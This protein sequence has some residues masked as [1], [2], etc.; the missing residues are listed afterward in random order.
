MKDSSSGAGGLLLSVVLLTAV[1]SAARADA[2]QLTSTELLSGPGITTARYTSTQD[3]VPS[4][5]VLTF[6]DNTVTFTLAKG[7][8]RRA[9]QYVN[10]FGDFNPGTK[11]LYTNNNNFK[12]FDLVTTVGGGGSGPVEIDFATGVQLVG[13]RA[14]TGWTGLE[15]FTF[16][17]YNDAALLGT[18]NT[19]G[20][21]DKRANDEFTALLAAEAT[22]G[23]VITRLVVSS[24][25]VQGGFELPNDFFIGPLSFGTPEPATA[26]PEPSTITMTVLGLGM[27]GSCRRQRLRSGE[28]FDTVIF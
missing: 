1:P 28:R 9:D 24:L 2:I 26:V 7:D 18:F 11:L 23:D 12:A 8:W 22:D 21:S 4:P 14:Q 20:I 5:L 15:T 25:A 19:N 3:L 10:V 16:S 6:P 13:L 27:F 17:V